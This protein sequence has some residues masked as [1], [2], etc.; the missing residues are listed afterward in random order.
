M[1]AAQQEA[2]LARFPVSRETLDRLETHRA[3]LG[4]WAARINLIGPSELAQYWT[5]HALDSAQLLQH[6]PEARRWVDLGSGAGFPGLV[7]ACLLAGVAGADVLLIEPSQKRAAFL[8]EAVRATGAPA[9][10]LAL[11]AEEALQSPT[12]CDVVT[13][14]ALA[15]L[16]R[17][18][19]LA[20]PILARGAVGLFPKGA[21]AEAELAGARGRWSFQARLFPSISDPRGRIVRLEGVARVPIDEPDGSSR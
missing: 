1:S 12:D 3:L 7:L 2:F 16:D 21:D 15:P 13:A 4:Q 17:I 19:E 20:Q 14:R 11:R 6:A 9:R 8:R 18:I 10:V 5:R